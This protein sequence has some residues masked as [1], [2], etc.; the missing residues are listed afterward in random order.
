MKTRYNL[1]YLF[2]RGNDNYYYMRRM[3]V[4]RPKT[5]MDIVC[6]YLK[7]AVVIVVD[8]VDVDV[9][10]GGDDLLDYSPWQQ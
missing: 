6:C 9:D 5:K 1:V 4:P 8:V 2:L 10:D 7:L 3:T